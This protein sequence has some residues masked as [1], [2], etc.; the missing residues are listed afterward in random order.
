MTHI[1][2]VPDA[3]IP[4]AP[5]IPPAPAWTAAQKRAL[6]G[7]SADQIKEAR[8]TL[9]A[10]A[11]SCPDY[12]TRKEAAEYID[13]AARADDEQ[14]FNGDAE[15]LAAL[16]S[17]P[18]EG[19]SS[20]ALQLF[21]KQMISRADLDTILKAVTADQ[22]AKLADLEKARVALE[23]ENKDLV[24]QLSGGGKRIDGVAE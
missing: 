13:K 14:F 20:A 16:A 17:L 1:P 9:T 4:L 18:L 15:A 7:F 11:T 19:Q 23:R 3:P 10:L 22:T 6:R 24:H 5:S 12:R 2:P 8:K 21:A